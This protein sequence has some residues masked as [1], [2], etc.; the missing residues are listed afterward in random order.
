MAHGITGIDHTLVGVRDLEVANLRWTRLGFALSPRG[1][2]FGW[3]TA[4]HCIMFADAYLELLGIVAPDQPNNGLDD[5]LGHRQGLMGVAWASRDCAATAAS[6]QE[7]GI[8][9]GE[10]KDLA[11]QIELPEATALL[12]FKL[13]TLPQDA[14]PGIASFVCQHL[15]PETLRRPEWLLHPNGAIG[16]KGITIAVENAPALTAAYD[17]LFGAHNVNRTDNVLTVHAGRH[18]LVFATPDDLSAL[19]PDLDEADIP[20]PPAIVLMTLASADL[21]QTADY[22]TQWQIEYEQH[23]QH[24]IVV[25]PAM[26]TGVA[27]EFVPG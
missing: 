11:R 1:R 16:L 25:P 9:C 13:G 7:A 3:G 23:G 24:S 4:N 5:F 27:L 10:V 6:L 12:R 2:H 21:E 22:L 19:Q 15:T 14:T 17:A 8:G 26:A 18:T 20:P